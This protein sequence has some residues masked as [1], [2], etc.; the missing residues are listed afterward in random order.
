MILCKYFTACG[1]PDNCMTCFE[2]IKVLDDN[3]KLLERRKNNIIYNMGGKRHEHQDET[4]KT[5]QEVRW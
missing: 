5:S 1:S 2:A 4:G 3:I